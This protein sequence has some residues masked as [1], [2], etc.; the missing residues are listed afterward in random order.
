MTESAA[1][2]SSLSISRLQSLAALVGLELDEERATALLPQAEQH[3]ALLRAI[4]EQAARA[5][6]PAA[7]FRLDR[8]PGRDDA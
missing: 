4:D 6:E 1:G 2:S 8:L 7:E 3:V 5:T